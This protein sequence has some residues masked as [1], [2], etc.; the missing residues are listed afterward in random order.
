MPQSAEENKVREKYQSLPGSGSREGEN[1]LETMVFDFTK[2]ISQA[3]IISPQSVHPL[4]QDETKIDPTYVRKL[5][6]DIE[7]LNGGVAEMVASIENIKC[8][9]FF[10]YH[11]KNFQRRTNDFTQLL[12]ASG[13][14]LL[15]ET[16]IRT[17]LS[18]IQENFLKILAIYDVFNSETYPEYDYIKKY[19]N[20]YRQQIIIS[21]LYQVEEYNKQDNLNLNPGD[22]FQSEAAEFFHLI[23]LSMLR[24]LFSYLT[25]YEFSNLEASTKKYITD[26]I[27][28]ALLIINQVQE[29]LDISTKTIHL[30]PDDLL[31]NIYHIFL[32][33]KI[34][35][36][37]TNKYIQDH[38]FKMEIQDTRLPILD[39]SN[40][41]PGPKDMLHIFTSRK[42]IVCQAFFSS[43]L[44][45][46]LQNLCH[47]LGYKII[48]HDI[49]FPTAEAWCKGVYGITK[50]PAFIFRERSIWINPEVEKGARDPHQTMKRELLNFLGVLGLYRE[51]IDDPKNDKKSL[52]AYTKRQ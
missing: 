15:T 49:Y 35:V 45:E 4:L 39:P 27:A 22:K 30:K 25:I 10:M 48:T 33:L 42:C 40:N 14:S 1:L 24:T 12:N 31:H 37:F 41:M 7:Q 18:K 46:Y 17:F 51:P 9:H 20:E 34:F 43:E 19:L 23:H 16:Q 36:N 2:Y 6:L 21:T 26:S 13:E 5:L 52:G 8:P 47:E 28:R 50:I 29:R 38:K 3:N 44:W 32:E 11:V